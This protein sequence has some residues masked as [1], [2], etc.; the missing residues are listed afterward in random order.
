MFLMH[1][2]G[3]S[4]MKRVTQKTYKHSKDRRISCADL[5]LVKRLGIKLTH[6]WAASTLADNKE[7]YKSRH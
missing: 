7:V 5:F 3:F 6:K 4:V 2:S 1:C